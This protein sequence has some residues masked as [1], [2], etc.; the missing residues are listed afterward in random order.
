MTVERRDVAAVPELD[1]AARVPGRDEPSVGEI[2]E[3]TRCRDA[4]RQPARRQRAAVQVE[5]PVEVEHRPKSKHRPRSKNRPRS[6]EPAT[7]KNGFR[8]RRPVPGPRR[9]VR[10]PHVLRLRE[11]GQDE[12]RIADRIDAD[13]GQD[14]RRPHPHGGRH[15][16]QGRQEAG[17]PA[18]GLPRLPAGAH[19]LRQRLVVRRSQHA[20]RDGVRLGG[21]GTKPTP[22]S[23]ARSRRSWR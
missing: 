17:R 16:D 6:E 9:L 15:G 8:R 21:T 12:P 22:L 3:P 20:G 2:A 5:A 14:L 23:R 10:R 7:S 11:Q 4:R 13:G 19:D 18:E 1:R